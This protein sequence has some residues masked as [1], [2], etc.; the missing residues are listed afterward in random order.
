LF[1][2]KKKKGVRHF[3]RC[4]HELSRNENK[5]RGRRQ[6][7]SRRAPPRSLCDRVEDSRGKKK[8]VVPVRGGKKIVVL[9]TREERKEGTVLAIEK[10]RSVH[11]GRGRKRG[12]GGKRRFPCREEG[13]TRGRAFSLCSQKSKDGETGERKKE[14]KPS[15]PG[16]EKKGGGGGIVF[17]R[18]SFT[19]KT[20][21]KEG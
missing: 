10:A 12:E 16:I 11:G 19:E 17:I 18:T 2:Q 4:L 15:R 5:K 14:G 1:V 13:Q 8:N 6:L 3:P 20:A 21:E 7:S 9:R